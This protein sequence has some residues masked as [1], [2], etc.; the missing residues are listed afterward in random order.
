MDADEESISVLCVDDE[1][2]LADL[3]ATFLK[4]FDGRFS[5]ST[6]LSAQEGLDYLDENNVDCVVSDYDMP[7]LDGLAFLE[8]V[9]A[10][11]PDL[12]FI[13]FT[14]RGSEEIAS[15]AISAGVSD[16]MQKESG[17]DQ[18]A[19]LGQRILNVVHRHR[20]RVQQQET[21]TRAETILGA[22]PDAILVSVGSEFVYANP[23]AVDLY[24]VPD[25]SALLGRQA[26][27][28]IHP[29]YRD[30]VDRQ[31]QQVESGERPAD[32][33]P[34]T[35]LTLE[36][37]EVPVEVT[38][39]HVMWDN[40]PG[41][42]AIVRDL[43]DQEAQI[44]RQ[45]RYEAS[46]EQAFDA[47]VVADDD[48]QY[49]EANQSACELFGL[50]KEGLIGR[51]IEE[52]TQGDNDFKATW[53]RFEET[54]IDR[55][56]LR[57]VR[58]DG[59]ERVVE[60]AATSNIVAGEHLSV[61]RDV[62]DRE[63][64]EWV[65]REM[66]NI[67]SNRD[68]PFEEQVGALLELGRQE[69]DVAYGTLSQIQGEDYVFE[70]VDAD[71]DA[72]QA[73]DVVPV[74]ATN[75]EIA[76][77]TKETLV[78]GDVERDAPGETDRAG[79]TEWGIACYL[80]APVIIDN[81]VYG[82][83]CFYGTEPREGQFSEWEVTLVDLMSRWVGYELQRQRTNDRL[84][85]QNEKLEQFASLVSHDL[86][87][88]LN[89]LEGSLQLAEETGD[90]EHFEQCNRAID[91]MNTLIE[92]LLSLAR[93]GTIIDETESVTL[94]SVV[95]ECWNGVEASQGT[96]QLKLDT[97]TVI[98]ADRSRLKQ[99]VENLIRNVFD[100]ASSDS[101][102]TVGAL[103]DGFYIEDDGPGISEE[104]RETVFESGYSTLEDGTG[105]G[106]A[107]VKEIVEAH[108]W[109]ISVTDAEAGGARFELTGIDI[110]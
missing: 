110:A 53:R 17:N 41:V 75:C 6:A 90:P 16:Y 30:D 34:R 54:T 14:G 67:I 109:E 8:A 7:A 19:V 63:N 10:T 21:E 13:L 80:G 43:S 47:M 27:E 5:T 38:A 83:F 4:Q 20:S 73:G 24:D 51:S 68:R 95:E 101:T 104:D 91:R 58:D 9:R 77:S 46:F 99:L 1:P 48:G 44:H 45:E 108:G 84:K 11:N 76:A 22:S 89:V 52:F 40:D 28:F 66:Y 74:S 103:D 62:T 72:I 98:Q 79:Y 50:E 55:G 39:R 35:L 71:D 92:D 64:R 105:F 93:A 37:K 33:I 94:A 23:A 97:A 70:I 60:Y 49:I 61:L 15:D 85:A 31:L 96:L 32:H 59:E 106:L 57:I 18:Y 102:V 2:G 69:L 100:H 36:G 25:K 65:I 12:P 78:L 86:R 3:T 87:N 82:T 42:V 26:G 107:I 81:N 29:D 88:P 56:T